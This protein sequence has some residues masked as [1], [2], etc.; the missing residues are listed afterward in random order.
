MIGEDDKVQIAVPRQSSVVKI[1]KVSTE[2]T[3]D[4][5]DE[6]SLAPVGM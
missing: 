1:R 3:I 2:I 5:I 6:C 4:K